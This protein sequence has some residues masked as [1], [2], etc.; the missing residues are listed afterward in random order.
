MDEQGAPR[1]TQTN[2]Q[3]KAYRGWQQG[4]VAWKKCREIAWA[5]RDDFRKDKKK[6]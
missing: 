6:P 1:Q 3:T 5:A 2:K 4:Q